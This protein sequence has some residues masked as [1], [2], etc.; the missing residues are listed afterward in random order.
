MRVFIF[1]IGL[2]LSFICHADESAV[3]TCS[4]PA[5]NPILFGAYDTQ[6][7]SPTDSAGS[8]TYTCSGPL[9]RLSIQ[10]S[11]GQANNLNR[12]MVNDQ[13]HQLH[14]NLY[15]DPAR[16]QLWGDG[17]SGSALYATASIQNDTA[18]VIPVYGRVH[19]LQSVGVGMYYDNLVVTLNFE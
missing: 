15:L 11:H 4:F 13:G 10:I 16:Q 19:P 7:G 3:V 8:I 14:Y 12:F 17:A 18:T 6:N 2:I 9:T 1:M 5:A